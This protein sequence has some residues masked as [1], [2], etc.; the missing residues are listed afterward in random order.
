MANCVI[1]VHRG[2]CNGYAWLVRRCPFL[3]EKVLTTTWSGNR[4]S[5]STLFLTKAHACKNES[6]MTSGSVNFQIMN[7]MLLPILLK[8][9][10]FSKDRILKP[11]IR[12]NLPWPPCQN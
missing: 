12:R 7:N 9:Y 8:H 6:Y 1:S 10:A 4:G 2:V 11:F 3:V 5:S